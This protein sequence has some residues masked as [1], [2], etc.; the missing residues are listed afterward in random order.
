MRIVN[1]MFC[2]D[3]RG[4]AAS[5]EPKGGAK[6]YSASTMKLLLSGTAIIGVV[7]MWYRCGI[8]RSQ[9]YDPMLIHRLSTAYPPDR[10]A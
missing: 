3:T 8:D 10:A 6:G 4:V 9:A 7:T 1:S 5:T 2:V